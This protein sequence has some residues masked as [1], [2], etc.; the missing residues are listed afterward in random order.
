MRDV[1]TTAFLISRRA[2]S[3]EGRFPS[4]FRK[5]CKYSM[6]NPSIRL[7]M[8]VA[9]RTSPRVANTDLTNDQTATQPKGHAKIKSHWRSLARNA[10]IVRTSAAVVPIDPQ[11]ELFRYQVSRLLVIRQAR[12]CVSQSSFFRNT[13]VVIDR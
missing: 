7:P 11:S 12:E 1:G 8:T 9:S 4:R 5:D 3:A 2:S 10:A 6:A 13:Q